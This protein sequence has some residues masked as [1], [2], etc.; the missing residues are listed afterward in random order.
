MLQHPDELAE[1]VREF[2]KNW[3]PFGSASWSC[4]KKR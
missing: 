4:R 1:E 2:W 3:K